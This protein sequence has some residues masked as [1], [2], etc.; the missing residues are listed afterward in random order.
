MIYHPGYTKVLTQ[1]E[2]M[3]CMHFGALLKCAEHGYDEK[4]IADFV[5]HATISLADTAKAVAAV[6]VLSGIPIG[7]VAHIAG[8]HISGERAK[9][10]E[11]N[12]KIKYY[13]AATQGLNT[14]L[15]TAGV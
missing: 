4:A 15:G 13:R 8:Q 7:V 9:E 3:A 2:R 6:A 14:G 1:G 11:L 12:E 10:K 5:K